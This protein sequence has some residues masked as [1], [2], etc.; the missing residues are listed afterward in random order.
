ME[1][2]TIQFPTLTV[3]KVVR[4]NY[5]KLREG[6]TDVKNYRRTQFIWDYFLFSCAKSATATL[7]RFVLIWFV[8]LRDVV[9]CKSRHTFQSWGALFRIVHTFYWFAV[10]RPC[11]WIQKLMDLFLFFLDCGK[12]MTNSVKNLK[13]NGFPITIHRLVFFFFFSKLFLKLFAA[14]YRRLWATVL[15]TH[16]AT[17]HPTYRGWS[18]LWLNLIPSRCPMILSQH[19]THITLFYVCMISFFILSRSCHATPWRWPSTRSSITAC[20]IQ[21]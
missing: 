21:P 12:S 7:N 18:S 5:G 15:D 9:R 3:V 11:E 10:D 14:P 2:V 16:P 19:P 20:K 13:N 1:L 8:Q 4:R 17:N 6:G